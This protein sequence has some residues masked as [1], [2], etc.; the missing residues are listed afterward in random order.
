MTAFAR[1]TAQQADDELTT[2]PECQKAPNGCGF[3]F[4]P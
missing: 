3:G 4:R 2:E 1:A